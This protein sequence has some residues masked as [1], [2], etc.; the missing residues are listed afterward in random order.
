MNSTRRSIISTLGLMVPI[1]LAGHAFGADTSVV[2]TLELKFRSFEDRVREAFSE[3]Q[4]DANGPST[5]RSTELSQ[6]IEVGYSEDVE[7]GLQGCYND[8]SFAGFPA[9]C[10]RIVRVGSGPG[11]VHAG[12]RLHVTT[13][14]VVL[15]DS[16]QKSSTCRPF[17][18]AG[19]PAAASF[20]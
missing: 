7:A 15:T 2:P 13:V 11:S 8:R 19:I 16:Q 5:L 3:Q 17:N 4:S 9:G 1:G 10:L 18:F 6:R 14:E 20:G 12:V